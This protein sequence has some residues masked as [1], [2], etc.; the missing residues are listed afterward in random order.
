[1]TPLNEILIDL[2]SIYKR[3]D[4][5][6]NKGVS[7]KD[8]PAYFVD[9]VEFLIDQKVICVRRGNDTEPARYYTS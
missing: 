6:G 7:V 8:V 2:E 1:M 9:Y 5:A 3:I 4:H